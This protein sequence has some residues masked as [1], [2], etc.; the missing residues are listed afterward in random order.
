MVPFI[1]NNDFPVE[2]LIK[3]ITKP[4]III[5]ST[6][7]ETVP[8]KL[9]EKIYNASNKENTEFWQVDSKHIGELYD[10]ESAYISKFEKLLNH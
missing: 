3:E 6:K 10:Y 1:M 8:Y 9:G 7:D 2:T 4:T 5:H